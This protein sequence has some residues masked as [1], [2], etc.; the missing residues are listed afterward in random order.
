[1]IVFV[2]N[3]SQISNFRLKTPD[4]SGGIIFGPMARTRRLKENRKIRQSVMFDL[5]QERIKNNN[6]FSCAWSVDGATPSTAQ[7]HKMLKAA[8]LHEHKLLLFVSPD[9]VLTYA[10]F[11]NLSNVIVVF[12]DQ[13]NAFDAAACKN[14]LFLQKDEQ[15]F[16]EM[17]SK[18]IWPNMTL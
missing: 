18:W 5:L 15:R 16:K 14:W 8:Q 4:N 3:Q 17:V 6:V 12:F 13:P 9:D 11:T 7:A 1:M 2:V 10:S